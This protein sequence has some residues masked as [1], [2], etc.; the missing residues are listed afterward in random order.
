MVSAQGSQ[1]PTDDGVRNFA[2]RTGRFPQPEIK[3]G[4]L[5]GGIDRPYVFGLAMA[6]ASRGVHLDVI[7]SDLVDRPE[8]HAPPRLIFLNLRGDMR[9]NVSVK[10]KIGRV[11]IYYARLIRY[12]WFAKP[13]VFHI[14]WDNKFR[15]F[16]RVVL[17]LYYKALGKKIA[18]TAMNVNAARRDANDST[19]NRLSLR[20][21]YRL[22]DHIFVHT[23]RM[24]SEL[25]RDFG[26]REEAV[27]VT[28]MGIN[29][30]VPNTELT[31]VEAK[32]R[33][34]IASGEKT[35]LFFGGVQ[36]YKGLEY[37][38]AAFQMIASE[39]GEYRLI[40]AGAPTQ[41]AQYWRDIQETIEKHPSCGR[42]IQRIEYVPD[43]ETEV[44]FKAAD[45][46]ALP[47]TEIFQS[48]VL[49]LSYGFGLPVIATDVGSLSKDIAEGKTGFICRPR[50]PVDLARVIA[51]Y[52]ESDLYLQL[53]KHRQ[54]IRDYGSEH[55][56]WDVA[57]EATANV[58]AKLLA[59]IL[60]PAS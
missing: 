48:G 18:F 5:T 29:H 49:V 39:H 34:G 11:L 58:Y 17:M 37:L 45:V 36:P 1:S 6:L 22:A 40:I 38:V 55:N 21:Q 26:V 59:D 43:S 14:L 44:Y 46:A 16:D 32:R 19:L 9:P 42:I 51:I 25:L 35:I 23:E 50:D 33:L 30:S 41:S 20:I 12:A 2:E 60:E 15:L 10:K 13:R 8:L 47:Y 24:K 53:D 52:F 7:G 57:A 31:P 3:I 56:S 4:L 27:T 54:N 28:P